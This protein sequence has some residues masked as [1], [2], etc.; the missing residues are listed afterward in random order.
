[1]K[2]TKG[3]LENNIMNERELEEYQKQKADGEFYVKLYDEEY[4]NMSNSERKMT[5]EFR[6]I[7]YQKLELPS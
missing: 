7:V 6:K 5:D 1:M 4:E 3:V 2:K